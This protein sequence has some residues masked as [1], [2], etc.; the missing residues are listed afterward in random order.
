MLSVLSAL[1]SAAPPPTSFCSSH[2]WDIVFNDEFT[3]PT[4]NLSAWTVDLGANNSRVRNSQ[5]TVDNVYLENGA[6]VLRSQREKSGDYSYTSG[7]VYSQGKVAWTHPVGTRACVRAKLPGGEGGTKPADWCATTPCT[8]CRTGCPTSGNRTCGPDQE[9]CAI[10]TCNMCACNRDNTTCPDDHSGS[11]PDSQGVW[12][13]HWMM[14]ESAACWPSMGEID[15]M[16]MVNGDGVTHA[17]YHWNAEGC[18]DMCANKSTGCHQ[19]I[20]ADHPDPVDVSVWHEYAVEY[21]RDHIHYAF[22]GVV[23]QKVETKTSRAKKEKAVFFD[24]PYYMILNTAVGGPWPGEPT[25]KTKFPLYHHIDYVKIAQPS[26]Q[27][28]T[29]TESL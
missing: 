2:G 10:G 28:G 11:R 16:E 19:S 15:I 23:F 18:N 13:A 25:A 20:S 5:G 17:T 3:G 8:K 26:Y 27:A 7:A 4:L 14:P 12:P 1:A 9:Q 6:L 21:G 29:L 24:T 22:D